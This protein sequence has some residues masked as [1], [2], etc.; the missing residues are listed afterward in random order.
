VNT[1]SRTPT[2]RSAIGR[3]LE[4][5]LSRL[6]RHQLGAGA[7]DPRQSVS[8]VTRRGLT[9]LLML[10]VSWLVGLL[11]GTDIV[12]IGRMTISIL[13]KFGIAVAAVWILLTAYRQAVCVLTHFAR[14]TFHLPPGET[15]FDASVLE[16]AWSVT[17]L[18]YVCLVYWVFVRSVSPILSALTASKWPLVAVDIGSLAVA[19]VAI[20]GILVASSPLFGKVGDSVAQRVGPAP[21]DTPSSKC[22]K[23]GVLSP[24]GSRYCAFCGEALLQTLGNA[25]GKKE[26]AA[27]SA[28]KD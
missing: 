10:V 26:Q 7:L 24:A 2:T 19:V 3:L 11:P 14:E 16:S 12:L 9:V 20:I 22:Q 17:L 5:W 15:A 25:G 1:E 13:L 18:V 8:T 4:D 27:P 23:C 6:V 28:A 21:E